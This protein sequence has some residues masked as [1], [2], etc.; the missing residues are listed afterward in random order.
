MFGCKIILSTASI[1]VK[2]KKVESA[3]LP[4]TGSLSDFICNAVKSITNTV[5][6]NFARLLF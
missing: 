3:E 5:Y 1:G 6:G 2:R 4:K